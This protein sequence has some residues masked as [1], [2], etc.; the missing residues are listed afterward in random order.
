MAYSLDEPATGFGI[1]IVDSANNFRFDDLDA[2]SY[3]DPSGN[4]YVV[5]TD[6]NNT[7]RATT[8]VR[9]GQV[10]AVELTL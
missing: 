5:L 6:V 4:Q 3:A 1:T 8:I 7:T 2:F 9:P 10:S